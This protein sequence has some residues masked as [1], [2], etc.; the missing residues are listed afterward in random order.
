MWADVDRRPDDTEHA[1]VDAGFT[2]AG[3]LDAALPEAGLLDASP[4]D[5]SP[6][7][8]SPLDASPLN[9]STVDG[10][11]ADGGSPDTGRPGSGPARVEPRDAGLAPTPSVSSVVGVE[12]VRHERI[13]LE[14]AR[15][16]LARGRAS[17]AMDALDRHRRLFPAGQHIEERAALTVQALV[18]LGR[19]DEARRAASAF[20]AQYPESLFG[21]I[22]D[23]ATSALADPSPSNQPPP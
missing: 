13:L 16:G 6:L 18:T 9:A 4:L 3:G 8:A 12:G 22:V 10:N 14:Q 20:R 7:D 5:A 1:I 17:E 21:P 19:V 2:D 11:L 15:A 23:R